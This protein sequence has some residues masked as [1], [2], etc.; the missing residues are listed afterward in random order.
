MTNSQ[1]AVLEFYVRHAADSGGKKRVTNPSSIP[2]RGQPGRLSRPE[3]T[4]DC[5]VVAHPEPCPTPVEL[6]AKGCQ[7]SVLVDLGDVSLSSQG[8]ILQ[9][10]VTIKNVCPNRASPWPSFSPNWTRTIWNTNAA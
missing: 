1:S 3:V 7:D 6:V 4:V 2:T 9:L 8:R 5:D 10:D